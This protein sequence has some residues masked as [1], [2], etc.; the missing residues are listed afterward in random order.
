[1]TCSKCQDLLVAYAEGVLDPELREQVTAHLAGCATCR[2]EADEQEKLRNRLSGDAAALPKP[3]LELPVMG[4]IAQEQTFRLRRN[5]M[6]KR[7]GKV[8]VGLAAAAVIATVLFIPSWYGSLST[9]AMAAEV[10]AGAVEALSDLHSVYIKL[11]VRTI[12]RD[13]FELIGLDYEFVPHEMWKQF[14]QPP[15]WRVEKP[16]RV[17]V[18]DGKSSLLWIKEPE[19][20]MAAEGGIDTGF[21]GWLLPLL[22]VDRV[23]DSELQLADR[24]QASQIDVQT[25]PQGVAKLVV[26]I[27]AKAQGD[28]TNDWLKN[29]SISA[30]DHRR[31]YTFDGE[32]KRLEDLEVWVH[33]DG[34]DVLVLEIDQIVY[35]PGIEPDLFT[36][37]LPEDVVWFEEPQ[38]LVD[39]EAYAKMSPDQAARAFFQACADQDWDEMLK[40]WSTSE[41]DERLKEHLADLEIITLGE[42]FKSGRYPG[43]FVPYEIRL[44]N[45][46]VLK[47][48]LAVRNDNAAAR[49]IVDGGI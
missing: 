21:V 8:G 40:F 6:R 44:T 28:F 48:N 22:D 12:A 11:N 36:L 45:G 49:Y 43:W 39:N 25:G 41:L 33:S 23:L 20:G 5:A 47:H 1:M 37:P 35:N 4:Q 30:S 14:G 17:V 18:M 16:G 13:N 15:K 26:T 31:V 42:P 29:T 3:S 9:R 27:E 34:R 7:Y 2:V 38:I 32:T 19:P 46:R 24:V 10:L